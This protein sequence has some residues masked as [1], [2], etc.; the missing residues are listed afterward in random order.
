MKRIE[1][2]S[3]EHYGK[4]VV[5]REVLPSTTPRK[6]LCKC[7]CGKEKTFLLNSLRMR[8]TLSCGCLRIE[9]N[10]KLK[11][12]LIDGRSNMNEY[13]IWIDMRRRCLN[14]KNIIYNHYGGR[15]IKVCDR[16]LN[17]FENFLKDMGLRPKNKSIDRIDVNGNYEPDNCRWA[18]R[19]EQ[20]NNRR[21]NKK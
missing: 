12:N 18:T 14:P 13:R 6:V 20:Q 21:N 4:L 16:W 5:I 1:I 9:T 19:K 7:E 3:G 15:G 17:S 11:R 2:Q 8:K 10:K